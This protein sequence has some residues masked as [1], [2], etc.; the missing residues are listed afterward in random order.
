[1][2]NPLCGLMLFELVQTLIRHLY[3]S[4]VGF[5][6]GAVRICLTTG[7][8][9]TVEDGGLA[10]TGDPYNSAFQWHGAVL[11]WCKVTKIRG[12]NA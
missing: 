4:E 11:F 6:S 10:D 1:M 7:V 2:D 9:D 5:N 8:G 3:Y 12:A